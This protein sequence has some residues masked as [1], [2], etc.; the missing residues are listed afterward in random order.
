M[1]FRSALLCA[2]LSLSLTSPAF[3]LKPPPIPERKPFAVQTNPK[4]T[5]DT[6]VISKTGDVEMPCGALSK[7][8]I[9]MRDIIHQMEE[10]KNGSDI[11][12]HG[13]T[14]AGA[15]GSFLI[16][17][18]TGGIGLAVGGFLLDQNIS[19]NKDDADEIQDIAKQRR[20]LMM[21][22]YNAKSCF[23]PLEHAMQNPEKRDAMDIIADI[24]P[25][26]GKTYQ[27][28]LRRRYND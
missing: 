12:S 26:S 24:Q 16:G 5:T 7:E 28:E 10:V 4:I 20:T 19:S 14:A 9:L 1:H 8:A 22:I 18:V 25:A 21:G 13:V 15:V 11:Q 27:T 17:S 23:G 2:I 6:L 3:A